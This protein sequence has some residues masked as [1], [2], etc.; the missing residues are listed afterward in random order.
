[1]VSTGID[2][3]GNGAALRRI[4]PYHSERSVLRPVRLIRSAGLL[5]GSLRATTP[6]R[7]W[8]AGEG[9]TEN[10]VPPCLRTVSSAGKSELR[11]AR[12]ALQIAGQSIT[13][14]VERL[15]CDRQDKMPSPVPR[16]VRTAFRVVPLH[17]QKPGVAA[18]E[19]RRGLFWH[20]HVCLCMSAARRSACGF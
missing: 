19:H 17:V 18:L 11:G 6:R 3:T 15:R 8:A 16:R 5:A 2:Q 4:S 13:W 7:G 20:Y 1:M 14:T 12:P 9:S 10:R